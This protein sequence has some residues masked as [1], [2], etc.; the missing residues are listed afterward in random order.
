MRSDINL[1]TQRLE[2]RHGK[3]DKPRGVNL[4]LRTCSS[5]AALQRLP[6]EAVIGMTAQGARAA[7][8]RLCLRAGV[9]YQAVHAFRHTAGTQLYKATKD[10]EA[11]ARHLGQQRVETAAMYAKYAEDDVKK[12]MAEW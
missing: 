8:R 7:L 5:I 2:V 12:V 6:A 1:E 3:G 4:S 9:P 10:L 11:V